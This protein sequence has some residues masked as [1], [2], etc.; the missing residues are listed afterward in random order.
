MNGKLSTPVIS[1]WATSRSGAI[2]V[3]PIWRSYAARSENAT[4]TRITIKAI[5]DPTRSS[6]APSY[7]SAWPFGLTVK[8]CF[9]LSSALMNIITQALAIT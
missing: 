8:S 4:G 7:F 6:I 2:P 3:T 9:V 5:N 1:L